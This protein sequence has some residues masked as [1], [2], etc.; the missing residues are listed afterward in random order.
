MFWLAMMWP[1]AASTS[2]TSP[3]HPLRIPNVP[4]T[5]CAPDRPHRTGASVWLCHCLVAPD[6]KS[7]LKDI[8]I[9]P[10]ETIPRGSLMPKIWRTGIK[11]IEARDATLVLKFSVGL[12]QSP[13]RPRVKS[14]KRGKK[15][16]WSGNKSDTRR[17]A[18]SPFAAK[19]EGTSLKK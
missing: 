16:R 1:R 4:R 13:K 18:T 7:L 14:R 5:I 17:R 9:A 19:K 3:C 6:E 8:Q 12:N 11:V 15:N 2:P 10:A